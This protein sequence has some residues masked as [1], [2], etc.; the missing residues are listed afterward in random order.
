MYTSDIHFER[1]ENQEIQIPVF[2]NSSWKYDYGFAHAEIS[3]WFQIISY[4]YQEYFLPIKIENNYIIKAIL[5]IFFKN[6]CGKTSYLGIF[7]HV[8][9]LY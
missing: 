3:F 5:S 2:D 1:Q 6:T 9:T 8:E 7:F 4:V